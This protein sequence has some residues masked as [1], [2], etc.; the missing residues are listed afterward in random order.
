MTAIGSGKSFVTAADGKEFDSILMTKTAG[1]EGTSILAEAS[2]M[3]KLLLPNVIRR[4]AS[5]I[6]RLSIMREANSAFKTGRV[7]AMHDVTEGGVL[8]AVYEMSV[9]SNLGFEI[10]ED[11]IPID[12]STTTICSRLSI[13]PLKLIGSGALLIACPKNSSEL[14][15][16]RL[17]SAGVE[18][19]PIGRFLPLRRG[20]F[21]ETAGKRIRITENSIQDEIW[22]ALR[23]YG[24]L[25]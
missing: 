21:L 9:A 25:S 23:K 6:E 20:R 22:K 17:R 12:E 10:F 3:K 13:N 2:K 24:N 18:C 19:N 1:L 14:V 7:H 5:L 16:R 8:G 15:T 11:R 4:G